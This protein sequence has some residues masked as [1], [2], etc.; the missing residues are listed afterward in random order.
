MPIAV[1]EGGGS[2]TPWGYYWQRWHGPQGLADNE[3][4]GPFATQDQ[5][6]ADALQRTHQLAVARRAERGTQ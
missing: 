4:I 1:F 6:Y 5:A 2:L 3:P